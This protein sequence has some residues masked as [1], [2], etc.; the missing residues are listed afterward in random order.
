MVAANV[1]RSA[2]RQFCPTRKHPCVEMPEIL[3]DTIRRTND[4]LDFAGARVLV[5]ELSSAD[6]VRVAGGTDY[7]CLAFCSPRNPSTQSEAYKN[8]QLVHVADRIL[9]AAPGAGFSYEWKGAEI[10]IMH[11][12][13]RPAFLEEVAISSQV[14]LKQLHRPGIQQV[15][16]DDPLEGLCRILMREVQDGC[17]NGST[18]LEAV[19]RALV[20]ALVKRLAPSFP[21]SRCDERVTKGIRFIQ[22][23]FQDRISLTDIAR[24]ACL[25]PY[26]FL[27]IFREIVGVS[28]HAYLVQCRLRHA[29]QLIAS[30]TSRLTLA[31]I[32]VEAGFYDQTHLTRHF[33]QA[34]GDTPGHWLQRQ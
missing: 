30:G 16:L 17:Q 20:L 27:R 9:F 14:D 5:R 23:H 25:S 31:E 24:A 34:F 10:A 4:H 33:R 11:M 32:A 26:Y 28:P 13:F 19:T 6:V 1:P 3:S 21:S 7:F 12:Q 15:T 22:Q 8:T 18:F 2:N 29:Q